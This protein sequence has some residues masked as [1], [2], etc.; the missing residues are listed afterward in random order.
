M[1][2]FASL[3]ALGKQLERDSACPAI[4][5]RRY[6]KALSWEMRV[7]SHSGHGRLVPSTD[8]RPRPFDGR[9]SAVRA[10]PLADEAC[11][12]LDLRSAGVRRAHRKHTAF[13]QLLRVAHDSLRES[14]LRDAIEAIEHCL[15]GGDLDL[16]PPGRLGSRDWVAYVLD[17]GPLQ[18]RLLFD[19]PEVRQF[20]INELR[21]RTASLDEAGECVHGICWACGREREMLR[22]LPPVCLTGVG[23][24]HSLNVPA[25]VS[26]LGGRRAHRRATAG[27]C[28]DCGER[29]SRAFRHVVNDRR[30]ADV[31][32]RDP[33]DTRGLTNYVWLSWLSTRGTVDGALVSPNNGRIVVRDWIQTRSDTVATHRASFSRDT[34]IVGPRGE[35][36]AAPCLQELYHRMGTIAPALVPALHR[37]VLK[38]AVPNDWFSHR[39]FSSIQRHLVARPTRE[40]LTALHHFVALGKMIVCRSHNHLRERSMR[41]LDE[42]SRELPYLCGRLLAALS[43]L[44]RA[45]SGVRVTSTNPERLFSY[46]AV[47]PRVTF[48]RLIEVATA[49]HVPQL[50]SRSEARSPSGHC[51]P[52]LLRHIEAGGGVPERFDLA[53]RWQFG[54][55]FYHQRAEFRSTSRRRSSPAPA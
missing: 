48:A 19:E 16:G 49:V 7:S 22:S 26:F 53:K 14:R 17:D 37:V 51:F 40:N 45:V 41:Q 43:E 1:E 12:A 47:A 42:N 23:S 8:A 3:N 27:C 28:F 54:L 32:F 44:Q 11:Y 15:D 29:V 18:G 33:D 34:S 21:R 5:Y 2:F 6:A 10:H 13:R 25:F 24:L 9:T 30:P 46:A 20:W 55:G 36:P 4:G 35:D 31:L 50:R 39:A 38:D 52:D